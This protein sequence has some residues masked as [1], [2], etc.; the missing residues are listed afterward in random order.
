MIPTA[1]I[2]Y[3]KSYVLNEANDLVEV[4]PQSIPRAGSILEEIARLKARH[5]DLN[6]RIRTVDA[7]GALRQ[8]AASQV[9]VYPLKVVSFSC[10]C[11]C[12]DQDGMCE[13]LTGRLGNLKVITEVPFMRKGNMIFAIRSQ[14][15]VDPVSGA[16]ESVDS[17]FNGG[18][19]WIGSLDATKYDYELIMFRSS[20]DNCI[21]RMTESIDLTRKLSDIDPSIYQSEVGYHLQNES[22]DSIGRPTLERNLDDYGSIEELE[23][24]A[25]CYISSSAFAAAVKEGKA[26]LLDLSEAAR[27]A[28]RPV[29]GKRYYQ[30]YEA[31]LSGIS[32]DPK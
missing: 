30:Q 29:A 11:E 2:G 6:S 16:A 4:T 12:E 3:H 15:L 10:S 24:V 31:F 7:G 27:L 22:A 13:Q 28:C 18:I 8:L 23:Q 21:G 17:L 32:Y 25:Q 14:G 26:D 5:S 9:G 20:K 1:Q 19:Y